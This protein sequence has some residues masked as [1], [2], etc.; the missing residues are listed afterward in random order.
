[1]AVVRRMVSMNPEDCSYIDDNA[2]SLSKFVR[3]SIKNLKENSQTVQVK[4]FS[5]SE[6]S[7]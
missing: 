1:M 6:D 7:I 2:I 4:P 5:E 3:N